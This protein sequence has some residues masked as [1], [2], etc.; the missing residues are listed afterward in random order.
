MPPPVGCEG[1]NEELVEDDGV[2]PLAGGH[3][4]SH[5]CLLDV[6]DPANGLWKTA[7]SHQLAGGHAVTCLHLLDVKG[8]TKNL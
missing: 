6:K 8:P 5:L 1:P 7:M 3:V 4:V 2:T